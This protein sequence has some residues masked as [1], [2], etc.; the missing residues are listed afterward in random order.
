MSNMLTLVEKANKRSIKFPIIQSVTF[1][2]EENAVVFTS[3]LEGENVT[4][5]R[6]GS[7]VV[8]R[9]FDI[10][11]VNLVA[12]EYFPLLFAESRT[13][14][15]AKDN[16]IRRGFLDIIR[17]VHHTPNSII[18]EGSIQTVKNRLAV[19]DIYVENVKV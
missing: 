4:V 7:S 11:Q 14:A 3:K 5:R 16:A 6:Q 1:A 8:F 2:S 19:V 17:G 18:V 9:L 13:Q 12:H 10:D 15:K